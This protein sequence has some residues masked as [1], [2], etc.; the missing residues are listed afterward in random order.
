MHD[1]PKEE[2]SD[3]LGAMAQTLQGT[4]GKLR[5]GQPRAH[6]VSETVTVEGDPLGTPN[7]GPLGIPFT[8]PGF[9]CGALLRLTNMEVENHLFVKESSLPRDY[10]PLPC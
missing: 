1:G 2:K 9:F 7:A 6:A 10:F 8:S 5:N 4:D 3:A